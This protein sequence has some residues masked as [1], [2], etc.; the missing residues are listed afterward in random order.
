MSR[1]VT[2]P[3]RLASPSSAV[4]MESSASGPWSCCSGPTTSTR[5]SAGTGGATT[6]RPR[7]RPSVMSSLG[8]SA[9]DCAPTRLSSPTPYQ[10]RRPVASPNGAG[11]AKAA[12]RTG[13]SKSTTSP[14]RAP[15]IAVTRA[16]LP[17]VR[18]EGVDWSAVRRA[19]TTPSRRLANGR[20]LQDIFEEGWAPI[21]TSIHREIDLGSRSTRTSALKPPCT[22][23]LCTVL[24]PSRS[25]HGGVRLVRDVGPPCGRA[26]VS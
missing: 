7:S 20:A 16:V 10:A 9:A 11:D 22:Y 8:E 3:L 17:H 1:Q 5:Q 15:G 6:A 2:V 12:S 25:A 24:A 4:R 14:W 13:S 21:L 18:P 23:S 19:L 26:S